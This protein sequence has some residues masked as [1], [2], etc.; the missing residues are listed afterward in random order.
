[1][2]AKLDAV[3]NHAIQP[4]TGATIWKYQAS[5]RGLNVTPL[6][7]ENGIVYSGHAEQNANDTTT[8]GAVFAFDGKVT[9]DITEDKLLWKTFPF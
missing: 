7:D 9:G 3:F 8:L 5:T 4:R 2:P 6:V 1:M